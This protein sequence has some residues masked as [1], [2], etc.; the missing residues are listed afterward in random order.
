MRKMLQILLAC[1]PCETF[2]P[3]DSELPP[4]GCLKE[5]PNG[6]QEQRG[7]FGEVPGRAEEVAAEEPGQQAPV[8]VRRQGDEGEFPHAT[9]PAPVVLRPCDLLASLQRE[10]CT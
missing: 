1:L 10:Y 9:R 6:A 2:A 8:Q 7:E 3:A 5:V 4:T